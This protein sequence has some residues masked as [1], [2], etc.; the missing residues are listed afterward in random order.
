MKIIIDG[1]VLTNQHFSGI[2]QYVAGVLKALDNVSSKK[3]DIRVIVPFDKRQNLSTYNFKK[4][5][6]VSYPL[7]HSIM[8]RLAAR[9]MLLPFDLLYGKALYIFPHFV[10]SPLLFSESILVVY[11]LSYVLHP[12]YAS[13]RNASWLKKYVRKSLPSASHIVTIS[14]NSKRELVE[15]YNLD[16]QNVSVAYPGVD[17]KSFYPRSK[18]DIDTAAKKYSLP[19][20]YIMSLSNLEPRKNLEGLVDAYCMLPEKITKKYSLL[21][22]GLEGWKT[23]KLYLKINNKI[24]E[25]YDI[26]FPSQ[27]ITNEDRPSILSGAELL[28]FP[29]HY[30]GFG[31]P[32]LEALACGTPVLVA[33][34]SS[35]PEAVGSIGIITA[36]NDPKGLQETM[37]D[38]FEEKKVLKKNVLYSG[39]THA[40]EFT[41]DKSA[42][43][44]LK[45]ADKISGKDEG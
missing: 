17:T 23:D 38:Y 27:Y 11:D 45:I 18:K 33:G 21:I 19:A 12:Q 41:W 10:N 35:L 15:Y 16:P 31:M 1:T 13:D 25:G 37:L 14:K 26:V 36:R 44:Y 3:Y 20:H 40:R 28:V 5:R 34:N 8:T 29:S 6:I 42:L 2:G 4:I 32:P 9:R 39:P 22:A 43:E 30:E 7:P 24:A